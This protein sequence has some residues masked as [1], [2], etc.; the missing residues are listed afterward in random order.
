MDTG[1]VILAVSIVPRLDISEL[2]V[3][4][5]TGKTFKYTGAH[6]IASNGQFKASAVPL[7][8][9]LTGCDTFILT[10]CDTYGTGKENVLG[11]V[12]SI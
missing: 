2:W 10:G 7:C 12:E 6:K 9:S 5:G 1:V 8:H 3:T 11:H 4:S